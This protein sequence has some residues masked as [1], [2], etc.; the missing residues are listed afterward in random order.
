[1]SE[2]CP[3]CGAGVDAQATANV[4]GMLPSGRD[5][6][7]HPVVYSCGVRSDRLGRVTPV[8]CLQNQLAAMTQRAEAAEAALKARNE[9]R[10][11]SL[12]RRVAVG[13]LLSDREN[14]E[15]RS[16]GLA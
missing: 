6:S 11:A 1:M 2:K 8:V 16:A 7:R 13:E 5:K 10:I 15:L 9:D 14:D 3:K 12:L 4:N